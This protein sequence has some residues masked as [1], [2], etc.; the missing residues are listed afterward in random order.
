MTN[1][2]QVE[3]TK[4]TP[5]GHGLA[6]IDGKKVF[7]SKALPGEKCSISI[8]K[9]N[10]K[11][12]FA[13]VESIESSSSS[14]IEPECDV[15]DKCGG[16]SLSMLSYEDQISNK[17]Q[18][19]DELCKRN[20]FKA[21]PIIPSPIEYAYRNNAEYKIINNQVGFYQERTNWIVQ[22]EQCV[23]YPEIFS[24]IK[25]HFEDYLVDQKNLPASGLKIRINSDQT[26]VLVGIE[27]NKINKDEEKRL[28][29]WV[30]YIMDALDEEYP[31][32]DLNGVS[33]TIINRRNRQEKWIY[34]ENILKD[35][36]AGKT[37]TYG[38][39]S[40]FQN[41]IDQFVNVTDKIREQLKSVEAKDVL[42]LYCGV[43]IISVLAADAYQKSYGVEVNREAVKF[44][45]ENIRRN[46]VGNFSV[47]AS[48]VDQYKFKSKPDT[49]IVDPPRTGL[50]KNMLSLITEQLKPQNLIYLSCKLDTLVR[51]L[52]HLKDI[53]EIS[54]IQP[55]DFFPQT[56]HIETLCFLNLK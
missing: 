28:S 29:F 38:L 36:I 2:H 19:I 27:T 47:T 1:T 23:L 21:N 8:T 39:H 46:F 14:R 17:Q 24:Y 30:S 55:Y 25:N 4:I 44:A 52:N 32:V 43:G 11:Y 48:D 35:K 42:E 7:V 16:C 53:Y 13:K 20:G 15:F 50:S 10:S 5:T 6:E 34:G 9:E 56:S 3:I 12:S 33:L 22:H 18:W 40:F 37:I 49:V 45:K 26:E 31:D 54:I 51:D 41:N